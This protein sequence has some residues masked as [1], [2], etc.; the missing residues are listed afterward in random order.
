MPPF[1]P[2]PDGAQVEILYQL[3]GKIVENRLWFLNRQPPTTSAQLQALA[4][5]VA[6]W[7]VDELLP[8]LSQD[9]ILAAVVASDWS[10]DP[11]PFEVAVLTPT[12]GG[13]LSETHSANVAFWVRFSNPFFRLPFYNGN[14]VPGIPKDVVTTN[15]VDSG[16]ATSVR[17]AYGDIEDLAGVWGPFPAWEWIITSRQLDGAWRSEQAFFDNFQAVVPRLTVA[18]RRRRLPS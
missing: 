18:P 17:F 5:G 15:T 3:G 2:L 16:W 4:D 12:T 13:Y 1:V 11:S 14:F 6:A 7:H 10:T 8:L 9:L